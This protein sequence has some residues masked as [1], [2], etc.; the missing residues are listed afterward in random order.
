VAEFVCHGEFWSGEEE[1]ENENLS[2]HPHLFSHAGK[3][4][5]SD[6]IGSDGQRHDPSMAH[7]E[8]IS[9]ASPFSWTQGI[10]PS[11]HGDEHHVPHWAP[12]GYTYLGK[13]HQLPRPTQKDGAIQ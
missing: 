5:S 3:T 10:A 7:K 6:R 9:H 8:K 1:K 4:T 2:L 13:G 12:S 11:R